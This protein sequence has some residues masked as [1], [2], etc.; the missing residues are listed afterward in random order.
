MEIKS[1]NL[2]KQII[3][4]LTISIFI[5]CIGYCVGNKWRSNEMDDL[6]LLKESK[7]IQDSALAFVSLILPESANHFDS[8][9]I[10]S[11]ISDKYKE[12]FRFNYEDTIK[13]GIENFN[14]IKKRVQILKILKPY[15]LHKVEIKKEGNIFSIILKMTTVSYIDFIKLHP[16]N[17]STLTHER[18]YKDTEMN[19]RY[20]R[21]IGG[22]FLFEGFD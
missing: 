8:T 15:Y 5:F 18:I 4:G 22:K 6:L 17:D 2:L 9:A 14:Y 13:K 20:K 19:L 11:R 12:Y 16:F 10:Y 1:K 3:S 21:E 7:V